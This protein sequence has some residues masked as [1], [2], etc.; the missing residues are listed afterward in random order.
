MEKRIFI[1]LP[2]QDQRKKLIEIQLQV[3]H[4]P[5]AAPE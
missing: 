4:H 3:R 2:E 5:V 1:D